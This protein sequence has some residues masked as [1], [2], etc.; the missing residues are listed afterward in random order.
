MKP[1]QFTLQYLFLETLFIAAALACF[2]QLLRVPPISRLVLLIAGVLFTG[3][4][5]GG[6]VG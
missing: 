6:L 4:A 3:G 5:I 1:G 2:T